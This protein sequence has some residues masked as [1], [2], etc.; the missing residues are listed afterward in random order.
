VVIG[1]AQSLDV[2]QP[3]R[4]FIAQLPTSPGKRLLFEVPG[5]DEI[6]ERAH[7]R[8]RTM[9]A[10]SARFNSAW[11]VMKGLRSPF[12]CSIVRGVAPGACGSVSAIVSA[13]S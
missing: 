13:G 7:I 2:L 8:A 1:G 6:R 10:C 9:F 3:S 4:I 11:V 5:Q 12:N